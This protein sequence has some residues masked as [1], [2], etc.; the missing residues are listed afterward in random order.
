[1]FK[2]TYQ[3]CNGNGYI[4][5]YV[6]FQEGRCFSCDS[7]GYFIFDVYQYDKYLTKHPNASRQEISIESL[8][9]EDDYI[10]LDEKINKIIGTFTKEDINNKK[11]VKIELDYYELIKVQSAF[12]NTALTHLLEGRSRINNNFYRESAK[13]DKTKLTIRN[14]LIEKGKG[15]SVNQINAHTKISKEHIIKAVLEMKT[16][17]MVVTTPSPSGKKINDVSLTE[18]GLRGY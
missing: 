13:L 7:R 15:K 8:M 14:Y 11:K 5:N 17:G 10:S 4:S 9:N 1:M 3:K 16:E 18:K 12:K 2:V 6:N